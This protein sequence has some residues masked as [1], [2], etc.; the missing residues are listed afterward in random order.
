[1]LFPGGRKSN[2]FIWSPEELVGTPR[3]KDFT[4][5]PSLGYGTRGNTDIL[6]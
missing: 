6:S 1:M 2:A 3:G 4:S 5:L